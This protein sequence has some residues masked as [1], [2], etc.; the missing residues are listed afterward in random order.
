MV[1]RRRDCSVATRTA[2]M[3]ST[4]QTVPGLADSRKDEVDNCQASDLI[5]VIPV[6]SDPTKYLQYHFVSF[7]SKKCLS[8]ASHAQKSANQ[9]LVANVAVASDSASARHEQL[10]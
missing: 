3:H 5:P 1:W 6:G 8:I 7:I 2:A 9:L 4:E 10:P